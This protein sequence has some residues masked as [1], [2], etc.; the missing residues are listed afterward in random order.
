VRNENWRYIL[1]ADGGEELYDEGTDPYEWNNLAGR[2][3]FE[4]KRAELAKWLPKENKSDIGN[5]R[6]TETEA[7]TPKQKRKQRN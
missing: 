5:A 6:G 4:A 2:A 1:Y 3:G 7:T